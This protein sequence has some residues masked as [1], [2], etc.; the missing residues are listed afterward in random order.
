MKSGNGV[1]RS[2]FRRHFDKRETFASACVLV[3]YEGYPAYRSRVLEDEPQD[4]IG[5]RE[6]EISDVKLSHAVSK[7]ERWIQVL[8]P[9]CGARNMD[10]HNEGTVAVDD[11]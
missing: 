3:L 8:N 6:R 11:R 9:A 1:R 10:A 2:I 4:L 7:G 5:S